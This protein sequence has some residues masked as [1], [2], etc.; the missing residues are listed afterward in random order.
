MLYGDLSQAKIARLLNLH[1]S[2]ITKWKNERD[3]F[4]EAYSMMKIAKEVD[5]SEPSM[6]TAVI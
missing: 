3:D 4:R 2:T 1:R 6:D 5:E